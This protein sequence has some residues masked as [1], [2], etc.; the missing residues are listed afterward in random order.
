MASTELITE[1][2]K[3]LSISTDSV[4]DEIKQT[5]DACLIDLNSAGVTV[6]NS[7][8]ALIKQAVKF[9]AKSHFGYDTE[10]VSFDEAYQSLKNTLALYGKYNGDED[11]SSS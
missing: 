7:D 11:V 4:D 9:Y 3:W 8:D 2:K 10:R 5:I 1:V 6:I